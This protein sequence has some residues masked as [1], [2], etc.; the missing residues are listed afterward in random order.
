MHCEHSASLTTSIYHLVLRRHRLRWTRLSGHIYQAMH[1]SALLLR[2]PSA[3]VPLSR[4]IDLFQQVLGKFDDK[5]VASTRST[6]EKRCSP[7]RVRGF[8]SRSLVG[9]VRGREDNCL[10]ERLTKN[11][12]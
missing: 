6:A 10:V 5:D 12:A 11:C 7:P 8:V 9:P 2:T 4:A 3:Q 1:I